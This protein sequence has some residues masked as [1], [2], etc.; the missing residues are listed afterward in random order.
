M[1]TIELIHDFNNLNKTFQ[2]YIEQDECYSLTGKDAD[3]V[4]I[5]ANKSLENMI[6]D[7]SFIL[8]KSVLE[9][10]SKVK[11]LKKKGEFSFWKKMIPRSQHIMIG[12]PYGKYSVSI[13]NNL[14][15]KIKRKEKIV[16]SHNGDQKKTFINEVDLFYKTFDDEINL[17]GADHISIWNLA[18]L[19]MSE[20]KY[21]VPIETRKRRL[22]NNILFDI[23]YY[24]DIL[25]ELIPINQGIKKLVE[26]KG[27]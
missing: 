6:K 4:I 21:K 24:E 1:T 23:P 22:K 12:E 18:E 7:G 27:V 8:K 15:N 17:I 14:Y 26:E 10:K 19:I 5:F 2:K 20:F 9:G 13:V 3:V 16:L 25:L 11:I